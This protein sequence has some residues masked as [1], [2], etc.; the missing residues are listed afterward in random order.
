MGIGEQRSTTSTPRLAGWSSVAGLLLLAAGCSSEVSLRDLPTPTIYWSHST[1]FCSTW[2]AIDRHG[3]LWHNP[4]ICEN[5][6]GP[7]MD[8]IGALSQERYQALF[9]LVATLPPPLTSEPTS[10]EPICSQNRHRFTLWEQP[11]PENSTSPGELWLQCLHDFPKLGDP[12]GLEEPYLSLA[13][14]FFCEGGRP[15]HPLPAPSIIGLPWGSPRLCRTGPNQT[16]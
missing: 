14:H 5:S 11:H 2:R 1:A 16:D 3:H 6:G 9:H 7:G 15:V 13:Q 12:D 10:Q 4:L 8:W